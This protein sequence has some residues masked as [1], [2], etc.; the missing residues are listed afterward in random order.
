MDQQKISAEVAAY[1]ERALYF[2]ERHRDVN[3]T[4]L[5]QWIDDTRKILALLQDSGKFQIEMRTYEQ[6]KASP[7]EFLFLVQCIVNRA[8]NIIELSDYRPKV[9][10]GEALNLRDRIISKQAE[11]A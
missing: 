4:T 3:Y 5:V 11:T 2:F 10:L 8:V 1:F 9:R 7:E 6:Y